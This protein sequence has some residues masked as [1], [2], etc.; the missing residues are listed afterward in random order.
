MELF[1]WERAGVTDSPCLMG[2]DFGTGGV[3]V[4]IF[5][6]DG[7]PVSFSATEFEIRHPR[8]GWAEQDPDE[9]WSALAKAVPQALAEGDV[10]P[11]EIAGISVDAT[12][13]TVLAVDA[14]G[15][16]LRPAIMWMDVR[17]SEQADRVA[18][19]AHPAL[20]YNG[21]GPVS[22]EWGLPKALWIRDSEPEVYERARYI[23][24]CVDWITQRLTATSTASI[25]TATCK[26]Y[27]DREAGGWPAELYEKAGAPDLVEKLPQDVL[28]VG[29][30]VGGVCRE[31]AQELGLEPDTPVAE[32]S[33]DAYAG[34]LGLGVV[35]PGTLALITGS[36]HVIIAQSAEPV[37]DP[38]FWG[39]YTDAIVPGLYTIE[40][41][42]ASTG[43]IVAWFARRL[44]GG[45]AQEAERT[46]ADVYHLLAEMAREVPVGSDGLL[47]LDY[48][49]GNRS[50]HTDPRA[51]GAVSGLSLSHGPGHLFRAIIEGICYGTEDI[52]ETM[53]SRDYVPERGVVSGGPAKSD[54]WMQMHA[55]VSNLP[56]TFPRVSEGPVLGAAIQASVGAGIHPDLPTAAKNMVRFE[57]TIEPDRA[58]HEEYRFWVQRHRELYGAVRDVQHE[59]AGHLGGEPGRA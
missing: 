18:G 25:N 22:A 47:V 33:V 40:A 49:Q 16:P 14:G 9:W 43:S 29:A 50:P 31:V 42:Q 57:R 7:G 12:S 30:P 15:R 10:S 17:A 2:I 27:F 54:L 37:H 5:D 1:L 28:D 3:R 52:L 41:G 13:S 11:T 20:R 6:R 23:L 46:G 45:V 19:T 55:D 21:H 53:R 58:R 38:G 8:P 48:F 51:R 36:S 26:Y 44:A 24:D 4:G 56:L 59:V 34:A 32:G 35:E 39:A